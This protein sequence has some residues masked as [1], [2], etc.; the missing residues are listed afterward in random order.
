MRRSGGDL[1][2]VGGLDSGFDRDA[3]DGFGKAVE[4][5]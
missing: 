3:C 4:A 5:A 2:G 1:T